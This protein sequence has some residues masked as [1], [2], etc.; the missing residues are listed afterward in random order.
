M[1]LP[2]FQ[3]AE[4]NSSVT[5]MTARDADG[6]DYISYSFTEGDVSNTNFK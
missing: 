2:H 5:K 6:S 1:L 4:I 3:N